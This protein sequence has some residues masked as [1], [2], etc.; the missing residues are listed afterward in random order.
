MES[1]KQENQISEITTTIIKSKKRNFRSLKKWSLTAFAATLLITS[2]F[3]LNVFA[4]SE[5]SNSTILN[6][7]NNQRALNNLKV[8]SENDNLNAAAYA[9]AQDM[10]KN[11]YFEHTSPQGK[12]PWTFINN[13]GY[14][15]AYAGEN[16]AIDFENL[17]DTND[18]LMKSPTHKANILNTKYTEM[19]TATVTGQ[20]NGR[21]TTIT[22]EMFGTSMFDTVLN[23]LKVSW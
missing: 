2:I 8:L 23:N 3:V 11:Q 22:V 20:F 16:L 4:K 19:G 14:D 6:L 21:V 18:A 13:A 12:T 10:F 17:K 1:Q 7:T 5:A 15:Y 9:K